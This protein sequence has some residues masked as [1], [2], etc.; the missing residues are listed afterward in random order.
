MKSDLDVAKTLILKADNDLKMARIG[1]DHDAP[2][3]TVAFH[4]QQAA[5]KMLKALLASRGVDY[6]RTHDLR[7]LI[8]L[9]AKEVPR[10]RKIPRTAPATQRLRGRDALRRRTRSRFRRSLQCAL[11]LRRAS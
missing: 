6:P 8:N 3:D 5:E 10:T 11:H 1:F 9:A 7:A 2:L 4:V